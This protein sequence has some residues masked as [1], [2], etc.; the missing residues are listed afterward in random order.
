MTVAQLNPNQMIQVKQR[1]L[2][3]LA[4][5]GQFAEITGLEHPYPTWYDLAKADQIVPDF[6]VLRDY[7]GIDFVDDD[8]D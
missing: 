4:N 8:F 3:E 2:I 6:V 7:D 1:Y 5:E